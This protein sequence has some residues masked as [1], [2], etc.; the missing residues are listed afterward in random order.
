MTAVDRAVIAR[1]GSQ[2]RRA[3]LQCGSTLY[4]E[5]V[6]LAPDPADVVPCMR[7][8]YCTVRSVEAVADSARPRR[9][10]PRRSRAELVAHL[11]TADR[12]TLGELRRARFSLRMI[13][14]AA[15]E[16]LLFI[17]DDAENVIIHSLLATS[18]DQR[19]EACSD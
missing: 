5:T 18:A 19:L 3:T 6:S 11:R 14:E 9:R 1:F 12:F 15:R 4:F 16:E 17:D 7:H 10:A 13:T 8:G 2:G